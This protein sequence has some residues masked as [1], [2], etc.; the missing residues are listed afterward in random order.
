MLELQETSSE[1]LQN[2]NRI[3]YRLTISQSRGN[4]TKVGAPFLAIFPKMSADSPLTNL[5]VHWRYVEA[6]V[7]STRMSHIDLFLR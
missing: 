3:R 1:I 7:L 4:V 2:I 6:N 5:T